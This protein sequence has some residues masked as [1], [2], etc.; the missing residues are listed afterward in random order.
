MRGGDSRRNTWLYTY[1]ENL[2]GLGRGSGT[3]TRTLVAVVPKTTEST[4]FHHTPVLDV[5]HL[6]ERSTFVFAS[7]LV[8]SASIPPLKV[9]QE[10]FEGLARAVGQFIVHA[11]DAGHSAGDS[12]EFKTCIQYLLGCTLTAQAVQQRSIGNRKI[13]VHGLKAALVGASNC[14]DYVFHFGLILL[15][16]M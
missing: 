11:G 5:N 2:F 12:Q 3:R 14:D 15:N 10:L 13:C 7:S 4:L 16:Q 9:E 1:L 6:E 8:A